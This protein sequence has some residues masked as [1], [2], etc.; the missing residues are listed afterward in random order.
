M[1]FAS[2]NE[3][4]AQREGKHS[5][6]AVVRWIQ[7]F[8]PCRKPLPEGAGGPKFNQL[9]KVRVIVVTDPQTHPQTHKLP[10]TNPQIGPITIHCT[11]ASPDMSPSDY[12]M[13]RYLKNNVCV[14]VDLQVMHTLQ[15]TFY[16]GWKNKFPNFTL[17]QYR[18]SQQVHTT[19]GR[20]N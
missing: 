6:L 9:E 19:Q 7:K 16:H 5:A 8:S 15:R 12:F 13:F 14:E 1:S 18:H 2:Q 4:S 10:H 17:P 20:L 11:A 3:K